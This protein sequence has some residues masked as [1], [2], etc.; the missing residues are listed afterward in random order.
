MGTAPV[1]LHR[2]CAQ[3]L[4]ASSELLDAPPLPAPPAMTATA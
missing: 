2:H 4:P 3:E 1:H